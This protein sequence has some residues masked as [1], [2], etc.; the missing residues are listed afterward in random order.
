MRYYEAE[1][2]R[3]VNQ[4]PIGLLGGEH[5][6]WFAPNSQ[7]WIDPLGLVH[8]ETPG[9]HVYGL[10][11]VDQN[12]GKIADKP[13]YIGITND[14]ARRIAEHQ[15]TGRLT[16]DGLTRMEPL[17]RNLTYGQARGYEQA[18]I[19]YYDTKHGEVGK[20]ISQSNRQNKINS[21]DINS[22]TRKESHQEYFKKFRKKLLKKTERKVQWIE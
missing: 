2:G 5:L 6:Y 10:F 18:L 22:K 7:I 16:K 21:F 4:D 8:E 13:Y 11:D 14:T 15:D 3:F 9:Y 20:E 17:H 12:T 1:A 19:E